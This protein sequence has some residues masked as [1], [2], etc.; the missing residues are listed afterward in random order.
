[1]RVST[2]TIYQTGID[3][4]TS[5]QSQQAKLQL[6][7]GTGK[8]ALSP[9]DDPVGTASALQI[10]Y[11]QGINN[12]FGDIRQAAEIK[13]NTLDSNL[14][15]VTDL[16]LSTQSTLVSAGNAT[17]TNAD[18]ASLAAELQGQLD[19][20]KGLANAQD[21]GGNYLYSGFETSVTPFT[22][23]PTGATYAGDSNQQMLQVDT[24]R[25]MAMNVP[26]D[27]VFQANG[28]D[29]F[30]AYQDFI[31]LLKTPISNTAQQ[32][33]YTAGLATAID[34]FKSGLDTV[35]NTRATIGYNLKEL[36]SLD[37]A[38]ADKSLL[39]SQTLSKLQDLDYSSALSD[40][41]KNQTILEA[42]QKSYVQTTSLNLFQYIN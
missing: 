16:L 33:A 29:L 4:I 37:S 34:S 28:N 17:Y 23:T 8:K 1:M 40:L 14:K 18:R 11:A 9:S 31:T 13:L 41:S 7:I 19:S 21:A 22:V 20:L 2:N 6:Q 12:K 35:L 36:D 32:T 15:N 5:L 42:A 30:K 27:Q 26:G 25:Q 10:Q 38:G 24:Q 3:K 39:Y